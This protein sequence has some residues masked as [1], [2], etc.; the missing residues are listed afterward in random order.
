MLWALGGLALI[1]VIGALALQFAISRNG[2]AVL[3]NVD[4]LAGGNGDA[5]L[6]ATV[7]TGEHPAQKL[8]VWGPEGRNPKD[9]PLPVLVFAHGGSWRS[10]DPV[11]YG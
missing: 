9:P 11:D 4:R 6:R 3:S 8:I 10:G 1:L 5:N 7:N 2:P